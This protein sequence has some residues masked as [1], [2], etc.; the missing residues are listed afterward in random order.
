VATNHPCPPRWNSL[1]P[2][3]FCIFCR[4][5]RSD[6]AFSSAPQF[7]R[8][9]SRS[10]RIVAINQPHSTSIKTSLVLGRV[11]PGTLILSPAN[12]FWHFIGTPYC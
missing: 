5:D 12:Q 10:G 4:S 6:P 7:W 1:L 9:G 3:C 11:A 8:S 2:V